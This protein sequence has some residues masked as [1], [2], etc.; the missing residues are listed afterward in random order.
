M[1]QTFKEL[2]FGDLDWN[3]Y[4]GIHLFKR[5]LLQVAPLEVVPEGELVLEPVGSVRKGSDL[6]GLVVEHQK[7]TGVDIVLVE[8]NAFE[9]IP[10]VALVTDKV[11]A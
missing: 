10:K 11:P 4:E 9:F 1:H 2:V 6:P 8:V 7:E 5:A 3:F